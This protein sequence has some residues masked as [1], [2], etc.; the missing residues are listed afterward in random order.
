[1]KVKQF[2]A[3]SDSRQQ[4]SFAAV[5]F[6]ANH[7]RMLR[8]RLIWKIIE[9]QGYRSL[10][11]DELAAYL[12]SEVK[13][14][15][16]FPNGLSAHKNAWI[17]L[18]VDLLKVDGSYDGEGLGLYYFDLDLSEIMKQIDEE[19]VREAFGK[20]DITKKDLETIMQVVFSVFKTTPAIDYVKS[21]LTPDEK[22]EYLDFRRFDNYIVYQSPK[23][24]S[25]MKSFLPIKGSE[26]M[27]VRYVMK[28]CHCTSEEATEILNIIFN[29]LAVEGNLF[30][31]H[32]TKAAYQIDASRYILRNYRNGK[33]YRCSKCGRFTPYNVHNVCA[34][35]ECDGALVEVNPDDALADNYYRNQYKTKKIESIVIKEHTAQLDRK[36]AK[37]YQKDFKE[38]KINILSCSTT[39]EM[40]VDIG[41]LETVYM[42]NVPP[43]PANYVQRAGRA[44]RRKDS[45]AY[46]LTYCGT[47]SHDYTYYSEPEKMISGMINPPFFDVLNSKIIVR[48]LMAACLGFFFRAHPV[49][50]KNV[51]EFV[52]NGGTDAFK[53][54]IM[55]HPA[56][57]NYY[58]NNKVLPEN[59]YN[60]YHDFKWFDE[61]G[62][63]DEKLDQFIA[64]VKDM[65]IEFEDAKSEALKEEKYTDA[66]YYAR[67]IENLHK[68]RVLDSLSKYCVIPKY[69]FPVDVVE[70]QVYNK[71]I[72]DNR[73]DLS[74]DLKIAISE[75]AP[76]S[77]VIVDGNKYTSKYIL[78]N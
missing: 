25:N 15:D 49:Y 45:S 65:E 57:L 74:R 32:A 69:G 28:A 20:Y 48:H 18:L 68:A 62:D 61:M 66:D 37:Q 53:N 4:A 3:F 29:N 19:D 64:T 12:T 52:F 54:Y 38:K 70:L 39:F 22:R 59:T 56:D 21:T 7:V 26:N 23:Q 60:A 40:G 2:L 16:L 27:V 8:K 35:D 67:Q 72:P 9:D 5:F 58:I 46:I 77:E 44:G 78:R 73:Y 63:Q 14:K 41:A 11:V 17:A 76:D 71:G 13:N 33:Y 50:F 30:K 36:T 31:K 6:D 1:M 42:R 55:S 43:T 10:T 34:H 51:S 47:G 24:E 75:Y